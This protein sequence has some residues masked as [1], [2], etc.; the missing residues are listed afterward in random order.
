MGF[1]KKLKKAAKKVGK[2]AGGAVLG[3]IVGG[4]IGAIAGGAMA[5]GEVKTPGFI[6]DLDPKLKNPFKT[7]DGPEETASEKLAADVAAKEYNF[8]RKLD[9]VKDEYAS[10]VAALD[11]EQAESNITGKANIDAQ[12]Q[13]SGLSQQVQLQQMAQGVDPSSGRASAAAASLQSASGDAV[14]RA[15]GESAFALKSSALEGMNNR[16]SMA[17]GEKTKAVA[18][19]QDIARGANDVAIN[20]AYNKFNNRAAGMEAVGSAVGMAGQALAKKG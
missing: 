8:A 4:P 14:G 19:L 13:V 5:S 3:G 15:Q 17:M 6:R 18:G 12:N 10:R 2:V 16:I 9:F 7:P 1:G 20:K 11:T